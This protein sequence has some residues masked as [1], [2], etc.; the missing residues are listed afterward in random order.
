MGSA[1]C[2]LRFL[3]VFVV[4]YNAAVPPFKLHPIRFSEVEAEGRFHSGCVRGW[5][6]SLARLD[7]LLSQLSDITHAN[8]RSL[9]GCELAIT[10]V[11]VKVGV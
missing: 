4:S 11:K 1:V 6:I 2:G 8:Y 7:T 9:S 3:F 10:F 5:L